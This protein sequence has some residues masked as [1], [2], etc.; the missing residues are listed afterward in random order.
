MALPTYEIGDIEYQDDA[1]SAPDRDIVHR[2]LP[3]YTDVIGSDSNVTDPVGHAAI[4]DHLQRTYLETKH[5]CDRCELRPLQTDSLSQYV[6]LLRW[7]ERWSDHFSLDEAKIYNWGT[8]LDSESPDYLGDK[9]PP[10]N[11]SGL[12]PLHTAMLC[13]FTSDG[14]NRV[15]IAMLIECN[16]D[17]LHAHIWRKLADDADYRWEEAAYLIAHNSGRWSINA[18]SRDLT[19]A[20][21][22]EPYGYI[23]DGADHV[24]EML[25]NGLA[26]LK[27]GIKGCQPRVVVFGG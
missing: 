10:H 27:S 26:H 12:L 4:V 6:D 20:E 18:P 22:A 13:E 5:V 15:L 17:Q 2:I 11:I 8:N 9:S 21:E 19:A 16:D 3:V 7:A 23:F 1:D 24:A 25:K 14:G